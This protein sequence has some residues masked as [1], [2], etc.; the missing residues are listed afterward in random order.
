MCRKWGCSVQLG[1]RRDLCGQA[2]SLFQC[3]KACVPRASRRTAPQ[4]ECLIEKAS[5]TPQGAATYC[6]GESASRSL[7][8]ARRSCVTSSVWKEGVVSKACCF[9]CAT[10]ASS[11]SPTAASQSAD[12]IW[13]FFSLIDLSSSVVSGGSSRSAWRSDSSVFWQMA[14]AVRRRSYAL[15]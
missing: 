5:D 15:Y 2:R 3:Q 13:Y 12:R 6:S 4:Y 14:A 9:H 10:D 8:W 7:S 1:R 11:P